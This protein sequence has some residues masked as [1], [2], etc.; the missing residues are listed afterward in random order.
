MTASRPRPGADHRHFLAMARMAAERRVHRRRPFRRARPRRGRD[1]RAPASRCARGRR[2]ARRAPDARR[3][4][5]RPRSA[6]RCPC[7]GDARCPAASRRRSP[8]RLAPQWRISALTRVPEECPGA[9]CTTSPAGLSRTTRWSSSNT[10][11]SATSSP[12]EFRFLGGGRDDDDFRAFGQF[13][14]RIA[15]LDAVDRDLSG[16]DQR[17]EPGARQREPPLAR[18]VRRGSGRAARPLR[19]RRPRNRSTPSAA[20]SAGR[21]AGAG[22]GS[23]GS[24]GAPSDAA[25]LHARLFALAFT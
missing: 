17:L 22:S 1:I 4:S 15:R 3:R 11:S 19:P 2:T 9:G 20:A 14:R 25:R 7:R 18:R 8:E 16:L 6:R 13:G 24:E 5:W 10:M 12:D 23:A 21:S